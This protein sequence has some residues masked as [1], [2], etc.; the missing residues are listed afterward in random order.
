MARAKRRGESG[1]PCRVPLNKEKDGDKILFVSIRALGIL[2]II[3]SQVIK[4]SPTWNLCNRA[5]S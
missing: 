5:K 2:Y 1:Q 4:F 3:L